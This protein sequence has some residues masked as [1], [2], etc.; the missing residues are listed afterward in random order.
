M[1]SPLNT[2]I[3]VVLLVVGCILLGFVSFELW[4]KGHRLWSTLSF[5]V[6]ITLPIFALL[7]R[8]VVKEEE[9][10]K[11]LYIGLRREKDD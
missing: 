10:N 1:S 4:Q 7:L 3:N 5:L 2:K 6:L 11:G 8:K 9:E